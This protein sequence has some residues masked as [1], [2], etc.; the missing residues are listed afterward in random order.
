MHL[1]VVFVSVG[2]T[3]DMCVFSIPDC[4]V[5]S[6]PEVR[7]LSLAVFDLAHLSPVPVCLLAVA[8]C[9]AWTLSRP[10][11]KQSSH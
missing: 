11:L 2:T 1:R 6:E 10:V 3:V 5:G 7:C 8:H 4:S 9:S